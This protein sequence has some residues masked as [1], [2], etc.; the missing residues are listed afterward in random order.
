M[1]VVIESLLLH[2][3]TI[4]DRNCVEFQMKFVS[5][6]KGNLIRALRLDDDLILPENG[7]FKTLQNS[8]WFFQIIVTANDTVA[9][10]LILG[11]RLRRKKIDH[12]FGTTPSQTKHNGVGQMQLIL[13]VPLRFD[14]FFIG[15]NGKIIWIGG[16]RADN[17]IV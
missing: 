17:P 16:F 10:T 14:N 5:Q 13:A 9:A 12:P 15:K 2:G 8:V 11:D 7:A 6:I 3:P 1:M 4:A